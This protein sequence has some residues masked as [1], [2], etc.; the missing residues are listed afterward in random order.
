MMILLRLCTHSAAQVS[1]GGIQLRSLHSTGM[2]FAVRA[3]VADALPTPTSV[4]RPG[5]GLH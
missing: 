3:F 5:R 4:S 2:Q 1:G